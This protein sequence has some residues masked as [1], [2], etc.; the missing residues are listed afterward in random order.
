[1]DDIR[2]RLDELERSAEEDRRLRR[3]EEQRHI[4][5]YAK[6]LFTKLIAQIYENR[7]VIL[8]TIFS[9]AGEDVD[10]ATCYIQAAESITE[11]EFRAVTDL[12]LEYFKLIK[13][14]PQV[15]DSFAFTSPR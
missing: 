1:M 11:A 8:P 14:Y 10:V 2:S 5:S 6:D 12:P 15:Y 13:S 4:T 9:N 7:G 3:A